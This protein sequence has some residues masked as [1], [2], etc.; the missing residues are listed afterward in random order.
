M[1]TLIR[2]LC[3]L[4]ILCGAAMS[5]A[6]EGSA[7]RAMSFVCAVVLL[8]CAGSGL[9]NLDFKEYALELSRERER[10]QSFLQESEETRDALDRFVQEAEYRAY[11]LELAQRLGVPLETAE[12][13]LRWSTE[14]LWVP[15]AIRL[16][17]TGNREQ[18]ERLTRR[19]SADLGIP[20]EQ[21]EWIEDG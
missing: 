20:P 14:G 15:E 9:K 12:V 2:E 10:E 17:G 11:V 3:V 5:L 21:Q 4:S 1:Q 16:S 6:P 19:L 8:A 18:R 13:R 7:R